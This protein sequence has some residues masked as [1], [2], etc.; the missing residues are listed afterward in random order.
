MN[1]ARARVLLAS[2]TSLCLLFLPD[3]SSATWIHLAIERYVQAEATYMGVTDGPFTLDANFAG[4]FDETAEGYVEYKEPCEDDPEGCFVGSSSSAAHQLSNFVPDGVTFSGQTGGTL[5]GIPD[6]SYS[7]DNLFHVR[8]KLLTIHRYELYWQVDPGDWVNT[9]LTRGYIRL[10]GPNFLTFEEVTSGALS[11]SGFLAPGEY[12]LE[13]RSWG[14][15]TGEESWQGAVFGGWFTC[16]PDTTTTLPYQPSDLTIGVGGTATFTVGTTCGTGTPSYQWR[17][18]LVPLTNGGRIS[19]ANGP[20]LTIQNAGPSDAGAYDVIVTC[21]GS[22]RPS[23]LAQLAVVTTTT[24]VEANGE[25]V[26]PVPALSVRAPAPNPFLSSTSI[27]YEA[28]HPVRVTAI[29][30]DARG[31]K[32]RTLL[33]DVATGSGII[34]WS[35]ETSLGRRAPA[36]VYFLRVEGG[37]V[38]E[39]KKIVLAP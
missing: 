10:Q 19:G 13:A 25:F 33:D 22:A 12:V 31:A 24:G 15:R 29:V 3:S 39:T 23:R 37:G 17:R 20:T 18:N 2:L 11:D 27:A 35:G 28:S 6:G 5:Y 8:F 21:G 9:Q 30:Y 14:D 32:V 36:G 7:F 4:F 16:T 38:R 26:G 34:R 1:R